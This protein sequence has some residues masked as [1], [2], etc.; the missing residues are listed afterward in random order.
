MSDEYDW[1]ASGESMVVAFVRTPGSG[2]AV[3]FAQAV[4]ASKAIDRS[5]VAYDLGHGPCPECKAPLTPVL[6]DWHSRYH[7]LVCINGHHQPGFCL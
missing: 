3:S 4:A 2:H 5:P 6:T 1:Q 7:D